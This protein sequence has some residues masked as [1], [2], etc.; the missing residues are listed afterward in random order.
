MGEV[1]LLVAGVILLVDDVILLVDNVILLV[2][3]VLRQ[4]Y[5]LMHFHSIM[6]SSLMRF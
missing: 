5:R 3:G 2:G 4:S 6:L 1:I